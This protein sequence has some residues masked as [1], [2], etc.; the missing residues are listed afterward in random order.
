MIYR[1]TYKQLRKSGMYGMTL[2]VYLAEDMS[3]S[4]AAKALLLFMLSKRGKWLFRQRHLAKV[5]NVERRSITRWFNELRKAGYLYLEDCA[6]KENAYKRA[7][8]YLVFPLPQKLFFQ[9]TNE[10][11]AEIVRADYNA[12]R[13][14]AE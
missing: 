3:I 12:E 6:D 11:E 1:V 5:F 7:W 14:A 8:T 2:P 9:L 13:Q 4:P 10:A